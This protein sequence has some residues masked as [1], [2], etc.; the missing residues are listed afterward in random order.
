VFGAGAIAGVTGNSGDG[1]DFDSPAPVHGSVPE[2]VRPQVFSAAE[3]GQPRPARIKASPSSPTMGVQNWFVN[4][5][6]FFPKDSYM[7]IENDPFR[8]REP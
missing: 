8:S 1:S 2:L 6:V 4:G 3:K 7:Q 5:Y